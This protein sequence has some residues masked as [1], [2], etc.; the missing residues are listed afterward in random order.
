[1]LR[2]GVLGIS[3]VRKVAEAHVHVYEAMDNGACGRYICYERVVQR[4]DEAIQLENELN[5]QGLVSGGRSGIL[6]EEIN[7]NLSNSKLARLLYQASQ[8]S[9]NQ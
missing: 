6:S 1:M 7:S 3:D 8:M 5:I 4:L 9:C 2:Q